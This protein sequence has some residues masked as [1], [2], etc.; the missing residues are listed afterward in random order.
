MHVFIVG[1][2]FIAGCNEVS[3]EKAVTESNIQFHIDEFDDQDNFVRM[4]GWVQDVHAPNKEQEIL[5][6]LKDNEGSKTFKPIIENRTDVQEKFE[7]TGFQ[8]AI[9]K[10]YLSDGKYQV[11]ILMKKEKTE[12]LINSDL[13]VVVNNDVVTPFSQGVKWMESYSLGDSK[14]MDHGDD[15]LTF[16]TSSDLLLKKMNQPFEELSPPIQ[17]NW[18]N[19]EKRTKD[20]VIVI[21]SSSAKQNIEVYEVN[22]NNKNSKHLSTVSKSDKLKIDPTILKTNEGYFATFTEI[23][24]TVNNNS[25]Q[26]VNGFYAVKLYFSPDLKDWTFVNTILSKNKNLEDGD[27]LIDQDDHLRFIYEEEELDK[28]HSQIK[29]ITSMNQGK[30]WSQPKVLLGAPADHEPAEI[31][32]KGDTY[33]LFYSSDID[34]GGKGSY[35]VA[36]M[37][38]A[39]LNEQFEISKKDINIEGKE[40]ASLYDV[41]PKGNSMYYLYTKDYSTENQLVLFE[42]ESLFNQ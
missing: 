17:A 12:T 5:I 11:Q 2:L 33:Y 7:V 37:K 35:D 22:L 15:I 24:G 13:S 28:G 21:A 40:S 41:L 39:I 18:F 25:P 9:N 34:N 14:L 10:N 6:V 19:M 1:L 36:K 26:N 42:G 4:R 16:S 30:D 23:T 32:H 31:I 38:F 3:N 20:R 8:F 29:M 27:L